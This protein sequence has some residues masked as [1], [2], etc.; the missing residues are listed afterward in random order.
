MD[1]CSD[2]MDGTEDFFDLIIEPPYSIP[3]ETAPH[4]EEI[5][6]NIFFE[7]H[8]VL[9]AAH[10]PDIQ[11]GVGEPHGGLVYGDSNSGIVDF[12]WMG[13]VSAIPNEFEST[14]LDAYSHPSGQLPTTYAIDQSLLNEPL[15]HRYTAEFSDTRADSRSNS[16]DYLLSSAIGSLEAGT[17]HHSELILEPSMPEIRAFHTGFDGIEGATTDLSSTIPTLTTSEAASDPMQSHFGNDVGVTPTMSYN[18]HSKKRN[19]Q[20]YRDAPT[21]R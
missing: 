2:T 13:S 4:F 5:P 12:D 9:S 21:K 19:G 20:A 1:F 6:S 16:A 3:E 8:E 18:V 11:A 15:P 17:F 14:E 10:V 7:Q